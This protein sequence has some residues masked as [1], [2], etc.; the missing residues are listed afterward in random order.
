MPNNYEKNI[1]HEPNETLKNPILETKKIIQ[2]QALIEQAPSLE[3]LNNLS[4]EN[5]KRSIY[6]GTGLTT[7]KEPAVG[8]P[9]DVLGMIL[10]AEQLRQAGGFQ[11]I[12]HHIADTHAK[13]N[14]F[15]NHQEVDT[16]AKKVKS[17][18][19]KVT[20]NLGIDSLTITMASDF[21]NTREYKNQLSFFKERSSLHDYVIHEMA[22]IEYYRTHHNL[23]MK[24]GW[25]IQGSETSI[26]SDERLFDR[27]YIRIVTPQENKMSFIY[28]KPGRT[29]DLSRPKVSPYIQIPGENRLL[30]DKKENAPKKIKESIERTGDKNLGGALKHLTS[31]VRTYEK[32]YENLGRIPIEDKIQFII[33][34]ATK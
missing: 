28:T 29:F 9:F 13:T 4:F 26:G 31:I 11:K 16:L 3:S 30:L 23:S 14:S 20:K 6:Y 10:T 19:T 33:E 15:I 32:L 22:D 18:L 24:L 5:S 21:D 27:E 1:H 12:I 7:P 34:K 25:V 2:N 17:T 8:L